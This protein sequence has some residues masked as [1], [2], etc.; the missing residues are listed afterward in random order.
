MDSD[1]LVAARPGERSHRFI[2]LPAQTKPSRRRAGSCRAA[3][4]LYR[5]YAQRGEVNRSLHAR[6][7]RLGDAGDIRNS[8]HH[9][10][11]PD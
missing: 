2:Y 3:W 6:S 9:P 5:I 11:F 1:G 4:D 7:D 8:C 10:I